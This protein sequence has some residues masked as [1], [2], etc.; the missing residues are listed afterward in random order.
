MKNVCLVKVLLGK[1]KDK[2]LTGKIYVQDIY[3]IKNLYIKY[4]ENI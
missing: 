3:L 2:A 1:W 4:T